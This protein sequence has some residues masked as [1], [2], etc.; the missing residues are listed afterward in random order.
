MNYRIYSAMHSG[1]HVAMHNTIP[2]NHIC[3]LVPFLPP[4]PPGDIPAEDLFAGIVAADVAG[5]CS[6]WRRLW[7]PSSSWAHSRCGWWLT[8]PAPDQVHCVQGQPLLKCSASAVEEEAL[9]LRVQLGLEGH[10]AGDECGE[11][12]DICQ[13]NLNPHLQAWHILCPG[14][15]QEQQ[16]GFKLIKLPCD[17]DEGEEQSGDGG[18]QQVVQYQ[19]GSAVTTS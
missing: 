2:N 15:L 10:R 6:R 3:P 13:G 17:A 14:D 7:Q 18:D 16:T 1:M 19:H 8:V 9:N 12:G 11:P 4:C 5:Y